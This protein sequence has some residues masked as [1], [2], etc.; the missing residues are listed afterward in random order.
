MR[1]YHKK[2]GTPFIIP[3]KMQPGGE[4]HLTAKTGSVPIVVYIYKS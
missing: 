4:K 2:Y 3:T 1:V